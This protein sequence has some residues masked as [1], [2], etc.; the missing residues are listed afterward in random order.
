MKKT[1]LDLERIEIKINQQISKSE[2]INLYNQLNETI[3]R[4]Y[5]IF[6]WNEVERIKRI[7]IENFQNCYYIIFVMIKNKNNK[8]LLVELVDITFKNGLAYEYIK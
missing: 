1:K 3:V 6:K 4:L 7:R 5:H 8:N 2:L